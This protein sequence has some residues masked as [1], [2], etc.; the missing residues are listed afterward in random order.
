MIGARL[1]ATVKDNCNDDMR[2]DGMDGG[3]V[4]SRRRWS[5]AK[6][7]DSHDDH[8]VVMSNKGHEREQES[9]N[10]SRNRSATMEQ[11]PQSISLFSRKDS[12]GPDLLVRNKIHR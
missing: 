5:R 3:Q 2:Y 6:S 4:S 10:D 9:L 11:F 12:L 7:P 8:D 1:T